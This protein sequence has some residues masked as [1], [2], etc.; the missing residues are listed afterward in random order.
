MKIIVCGL[1]KTGK[2]TFCKQLKQ[3]MPNAN[4][5]VTEALRNGFQAM[6]PEQMKEWGTK[7]SVQRRTLFPVFVKEFVDWNERFA[8]C[9]TI[10][11][12]SLLT[13]QDAVNVAGTDG[14]VV[15]FGLGGKKLDEMLQNIHKYEKTADYTANLS[16]NQL[17]KFWGDLEEEDRKNL[18]F[19]EE[20]GVLYIDATT[21]REEVFNVVFHK[22]QSLINR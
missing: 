2:T 6:L 22:L 9:C 16:N 4:L 20:N 3:Q 13:P 14:F 7:T 12:A 1:P 18:K 8:N 19:C 11:D 17:L 5:V 10:L 21:N 15:C